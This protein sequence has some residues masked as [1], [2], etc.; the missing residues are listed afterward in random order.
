MRWRRQGSI[1][2]DETELALAGSL[3]PRPSFSTAAPIDQ[4]IYSISASFKK[5]H[6]YLGLMT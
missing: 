6:A 5:Q 3:T 4:W 1:A 2:N